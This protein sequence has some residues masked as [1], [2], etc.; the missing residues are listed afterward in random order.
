M[1]SDATARRLARLREELH[2]EGIPISVDKPGMTALLEELDYARRPATH[3]GNSPRFGAIVAPDRTIADGNLGLPAIV[4]PT[5]LDAGMIRRMADGR[6]SF[7][8]RFADGQALVSFD[9]TIEHE[10]TAVQVALEAGVTVVQRQ[11]TG[12]V[13]VFDRR[14]VITWDGS[15]WW[16]K[17]LAGRLAADIRAQLDI[18]PGTV[19]DAIAE[20]CVHWLSPNRV[21]A[22]LVW[23]IGEQLDAEQLGT[24][25]SVEVL[26]IDVTERLHFAAALNMLAQTDRAA[27]VEPSGTIRT[28]GVALRYNDGARQAVPPYRGTR[29]TSALRYSFGEPNALVFAVS[30]SG[31][32]SV[33]HAGQVI[34][35][36]STTPPAESPS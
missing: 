32:V 9:R 4:E 2:D 31:P 8:A 3:E 15:R 34:S 35:I 26:P 16:S 18:P 21:G 23:Q 19:L 14:L 11:P 27:I 1:P 7:I 6:T 29:H 22:V 17:P 20:L 30:S 24:A 5:E 13:R 36:A 33:M 28:I 12:W 25:A 10:A